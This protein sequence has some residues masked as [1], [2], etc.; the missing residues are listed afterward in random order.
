MNDQRLEELLPFYV[1][2]T[3][4]E[5]EREQVE[6]WLQAHPDA[7][8]E[9]QWLRSLQTRVREDVPP[10]SAEVG[11]ERALRRIRTEGPAPQGVRRAAVQPG[12]WE[13]L[14]GALASLVPPSIV[15]PALAGALAL[16]AVQGLVIVQLMERHEDDSTEL[17]TLRSDA[18]PLEQGPYLKLN[19][20]ADAREADIRMLLVGINGSLAAGP[21]QLGDYYVRVP[22]QRLDAI[23]AQL[24]VNPIVD[25]VAVVDGLPARQ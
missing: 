17:R 13:R 20:K 21:G 6:R 16:V 7:Q 12:L 24:K 19:F 11:L 22:A 9:A 15:R 2:G 5:S 14:R 23:T 10:V 25:G 18:A 3:L 8:A 1:N 4:A